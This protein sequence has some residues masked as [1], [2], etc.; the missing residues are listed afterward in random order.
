MTG[1]GSINDPLDLPTAL[2]LQAIAPG[3]TVYLRAGTYTGDFVSTIAGSSVFPIT[4]KPYPGESVIVDGS[5]TINGAD[6]I[7][8]GIIFKYSGW[9]SRST[10]QAGST[11]S[12][13]PY[14]KTLNVYG[15]RTKL[16]QCTMHD[17]AQGCGFWEPTIDGT[18]EECLFL[19]NGWSGADRGHGHGIYTQNQT[20]TKTITRCVFVP[21][22]SSYSIHAYTESSHIQGFNIQEC[23]SIGKTMLFGGYQPADR[24]AVTRCALWGGTLQT[25]FDLAQANGT[26]TLTDNILANGATRSTAGTWTSLTETGTDHAT[27]DRILTYGGLVIVFNQSNVASVAAPIAGTYRNCLNPA[28]T[29]ALAAGGAL[30]MTGWTVATPLAAAAPLTSNTFPTFGAFLV[31]P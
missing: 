4:I 5:L 10:S 7:W 13:I 6:T 9:A 18:I 24:L 31:T 16:Y 3:N 14:T 2:G 29:I 23:V 17:L 30:P 19:N 22:Y 28:E 8:Q 27:G 12:D 25:G 20:G 15:A 26:A 1:L 11:P 21:G